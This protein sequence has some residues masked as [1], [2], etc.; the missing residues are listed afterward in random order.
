MKHILGLDIGTNSIGW[1]LVMED[2]AGSISIVKT[3]VHIFPI[4]TLVDDKSKKEKTK[5]AQRREYRGAS[6]MRYRYKLRRKNLKKL[7][8]D[9]RM[10]PDYSQF[11]RQKGRKQAFE[12]Y[13]LRAAA[14]HERISL[15]ELGRIF[16]LLNKYRGFQSNANKLRKEE[17]EEG[18]VKEGITEL[19]GFMKKRGAS[20]IGEYFYKMFALGKKMYDENKWHNDNEPVDERAIASNGDIILCNSNGIRRHYGR[21]TSREMYKQEFD[22]IWK[23]QRNYYQDILTGGPEELKAIRQLPYQ[24]KIEELKAFQKTLYWKIKEYCI[25]YQRPLKSQK[26]YVSNCQFEP[27]KKVIP[28]SHPLFQEFRLFKQLA[29]IRYSDEENYKMPLK[30]EWINKLSAFLKINEIIYLNPSKKTSAE[31]LPTFAD[32]L[33]LTGKDQE[34]IQD[35]PQLE[36]YIIGNRTY[37]SFIEALG[38]DT[39][40]SFEKE[41]K[42]ERLWHH[43]YLAKDGLLKANEWLLDILTDHSPSKWGLRPV[44]AEKLIYNGLEDGYG[45][46]STKVLRKI[47]PFMRLG[48]DENNA[49]VQA[50]YLRTLDMINNNTPLKGKISS[51]KYQE[52]RNPVVEKAV[53]QAIKIV[54]SILASYKREIDQESFEVRIESTREF[55]KPKQ[56][57]ELMRRENTDKDKLR[58]EYASFLNSRRELM[59]LTRKIE[60]YDSLVNKFELWLEMGFDKDDK[61]FKEG[62]FMA[63]ARVIR[64][65]DRL[66]HKLWLECNRICPYSGKIISL[67]KVFSYEIEIEHII[68]ISRSLDDSY[69]NKTLTYFDINKE[70]GARTSL[71][72][73]KS[74][75]DLK[76]FK[77]RISSSH[78]SPAKIDQ[79]LKENVPT[80]FTNDQ[81]ANASYIATYVR[82]KVQEICRT[83]RFTNGS[84][85][86]ELRKKDWKLSSLL[87]KIRYQE[88]TGID[89]NEIFQMYYSF[90]YDFKAWMCKKLQSNDIKIDWSSLDENK[91]VKEYEMATKN[92]LTY[93]WNK[94]REFNQFQNRSGKKDRSDHRQ[95]AVD[96]FIIACTSLR[97]TQVLSTYNRVKEEKH[98]QGRDEI[99]RPFLEG[100]L[101]DSIESIL[102]SHLATQNLI[103]KRVNRI[104]T[105]QG[106][107]KH[108]TFSPQGKLHQESFY[109]KINDSFVRRVELYADERQEKKLFETVNDLEY[110]G[111]AKDKWHYV[112]D[113]GLHG[114]IKLRLETIGKNALSKES[115]EQQPFHMT[116]PKTPERFTSKKGKPLPVIK[117]V[118]YRFNVERSMINL[119]AKDEHGQ[120]LFENRWVDNDT[121]YVMVFY[122]IGKKRIA[123]PLSFF[124]AVRRKQQM[125]NFLPDEIEY[126][127]QTYGINPSMP[128]LKMGDIVVLCKKEEN[129]HNIDWADN[130]W[131]AKRLFKVKGLSTSITHNEEHGDYEYGRIT[132]IA[133]NRAL[134]ERPPTLKSLEEALK[135]PSFTLSHDKFD[136]IKVR[137]DPL[138]RIIGKGEEC[139]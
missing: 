43:L 137:L 36:R 19:E 28:A 42:L 22:E 44:Q 108:H 37:A 93:F 21:Y 131:L 4:G 10:L 24:Q 33:G 45:A 77:K 25:Y 1:A 18:K 129:I 116:S 60:K 29:D 66:K 57:R 20:T 100:E 101:K 15:T 119:P 70:K 91:E 121:N 6:R 132:L 46:Y 59:G 111:K 75:N 69:N 109:S 112:P 104:K 115:L 82:R 56:E 130:K 13:K 113:E 30:K 72:Y 80:D 34:F 16:L 133:I 92:E 85:T 14:L 87:E 38:K 138:G 8:N 78:F 71:E 117:S 67:S 103:K 53:S 120:I 118:R 86:A 97:I 55:K 139:Y 128:W 76:N 68:P 123:R 81:L 83:V 61:Q 31:G 58:E 73:M 84:A 2:D 136:A 135:K 65:E 52:L 106:T 26:R 40:E 12:F 47:L 63:F 7:L 62:D 99:E 9:A 105:A 124:E 126:R 79:F 94:V 110:A 39:F 50:G 114:N 90:K 27:R 48:H 11:A 96:A 95:H 134:S 64:P 35:D 32:V 51:L 122:E 125:M 17:D 5:N 41:E 23:Q 89:M 88:K 102:V 74:K 127:G 98:L 107:I 54:N 49:L 3:G